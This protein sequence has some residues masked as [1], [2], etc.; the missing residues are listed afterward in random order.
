MFNDGEELYHNIIKDCAIFITNSCGV[1]LSWNEGC[2]NLLGFELNEF[3]G[4]S[5]GQLFSA[6]SVNEIKRAE[7]EGEAS[8]ARWM[9][10]KGGERFWA[11]ETTAA[12]RDNKG[13]LTGFTKVVSDLSHSERFEEEL[14]DKLYLSALI[15]SL[16]YLIW[17]CRPDGECDYLSPQ[18]KR[19]TGVPELEHL[20]FGWLNQLHPDDREEV[21]GA[22][23][24]A[25]KEN[26][27]FIAEYRIRGKNGKYRWFRAQAL[28]LKNSKGE[29][30]KWFGANTDIEDQKLGEL[31]LDERETTSAYLAAKEIR[32]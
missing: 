10:R 17:T 26:R 20:G 8:V 5:V 19:Y 7:K 14:R 31:S 32:K 4:K 1:I 13:N 22:W 30:F 3:I 9:M 16:P 25:V 11:S 15:D 12:I 2:K 28:P 18:W 23:K 27:P 29:I 6:E 21:S 24:R